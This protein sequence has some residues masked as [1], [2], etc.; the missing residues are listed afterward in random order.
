MN[1]TLSQELLIKYL[2]KMVTKVL[3]SFE[4]SHERF[5]EGTREKLVLTGNPVRKEILAARKSVAR[6]NLG[7]T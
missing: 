3:T 1:K 6:R 4:D 5:P 7:I 2:A